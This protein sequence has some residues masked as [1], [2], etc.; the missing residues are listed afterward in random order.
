M[1][2]EMCK[3]K[4]CNEID[5]AGVSGSFPKLILASVLKFILILN[6]TEIFE[7]YR[8]MRHLPFN[9][10]SS[11]IFLLMC[12]AL[13]YYFGRRKQSIRM[14]MKSAICEILASV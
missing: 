1:C 11:V 4:F 3:L 13:Y 10:C 6:L 8:Q 9:K 12:C 14:H 2:P 7:L 5:L